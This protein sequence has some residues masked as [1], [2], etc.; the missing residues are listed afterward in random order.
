MRA[1][2]TTVDHD[3]PTRRAAKET[4]DEKRIFCSKCAAEP[5]S[6]LSLLDFPE[7]RSIPGIQVPMRGDNLGRIIRL[8]YFRR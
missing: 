5:R 6:F 3:D 1:T 4:R 8:G 7:G 2:G